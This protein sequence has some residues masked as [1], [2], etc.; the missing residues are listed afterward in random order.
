MGANSAP[1]SQWAEPRL[2][3]SELERAIGGRFALPSLDMDSATQPDSNAMSR[4]SL[5]ES[6][7]R[8][9]T[10]VRANDLT[11]ARRLLENVVQHGDPSQREAARDLLS[12]LG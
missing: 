6:L 10:L 3:M 4:A 5:A 7:E 1:Q 12:R 2:E 11:Q 8:A 9:A